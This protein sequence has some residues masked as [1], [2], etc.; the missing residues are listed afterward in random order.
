MEELKPCLFCGCKNIDGFWN[1]YNEYEVRCLACK[2]RATS[3][4]IAE[5]AWNTR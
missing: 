5:A 1:E 3:Q 2:M 4:T